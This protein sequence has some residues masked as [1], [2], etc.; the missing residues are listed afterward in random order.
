MQDSRERIC[1]VLYCYVVA[2]SLAGDSECL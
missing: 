2:H 1:S